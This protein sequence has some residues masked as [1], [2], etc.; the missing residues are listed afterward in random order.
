MK[1]EFPPP[2]RI[3]ENGHAIGS[4]TP[5]MVLQRASELAVINGRAANDV[6]PNDLTAAQQE[7]TGSGPDDEPTD[8]VNTD[9]DTNVWNPVPGS[10]GHQTP[11]GRNDEEEEWQ[12]DSIRLVEEGMA[13]AQHDQMLRAIQQENQANAE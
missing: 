13:E 12:V 1:S 10:A 5:A 4:V 11:N 2:G 9:E 8:V 3:T 6:W 7:L